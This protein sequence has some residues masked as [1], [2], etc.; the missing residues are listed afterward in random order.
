MGRAFEWINSVKDFVQVNAI[1]KTSAQTSALALSEADAIAVLQNSLYPGAK[2]ES[3]RMVLAWCKATG[4][5]PMKKPIHIVPMWVKDAITGQGG[6]RDV[7]MPGIGTYRTDAAQSGQYAGKGEPEFGPDVAG[8]VG[9]ARITYPKW[10]KVTVSRLVG[11]QIRHFTAME[12]WLE[13]YA[14]AGRDKDEPN[15]MWRKRPYGQ[16]AKCFDTETEVLTDRGFQRFNQVTGRILQAGDDGLE[17]TDAKPFCQDYDGEMIVADGTRLNFS[18]TP[19][20]DMM[21]TIGKVEAG[22]LYDQATKDAGKWF[23]PRAPI[24]KL[25]DAPISDGVLRLAGYYL[26]DGSHTGYRQFRIGASREYKIEAL[27]EV[28]LFTMETVKKAAG[29]IAMLGGRKIRTGVDQANFVYPFALISDLVTPAKQIHPTN[30]L[31]L[32]QRQARIMVDALIEFDG[33]DN[34][35]GVRRLSQQH[36]HVRTA[37]EI[38]TIHAGMSVSAWTKT[39][40]TVSEASHFSVVRGVEKNGASLVKRKNVV[41]KVWCVT[42]PSGVI[43]VRR[44]GFSMLCGN[45]AESQALRMAF[46]DECGNT[47]TQEEM[48][49]KTFD[50]VTLDHRAEPAA[51]IEAPPPP[52]PT[53][54]V[55]DMVRERLAE[56]ESAA[57]VIAVGELPQVKRAEAKAPPKVW[58]EIKDMLTDRYAVFVNAQTPHDPATGEVTADDLDDQIPL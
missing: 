28:G 7:L 16:L 20:H 57:D 30:I 56:C 55:R 6:M 29:N 58:E 33:S 10:C 39:A 43:V 13:N 34:G 1:T 9:N 54:S 3:I 37:F 14:T 53:Q 26:A 2:P 35:G 11:G 21:T 24:N 31:A 32:S 12:F 49:G 27:R 22:R 47:N 17:A 42:V 38:L 51:A 19:N 46:P 23:L 48:E 40:A 36:P 5:D 18:V 52:A 4:R 44:H 45:C 15:A 41:G 25:A 50:G 8:A